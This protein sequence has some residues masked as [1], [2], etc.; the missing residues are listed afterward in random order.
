MGSSRIAA[1][2]KVVDA[3]I[4]HESTHEIEPLVATFGANPEWHN[5][6]GDEVLHGHEAIRT[7][8]AAL[9]AG[10]PDFY[11][12]IRQK[13]VAEEAIVV[14]GYLGGTHRAEWMGIPAT[15]KSMRIPFCVVFT[16]T[17]DDKLKAELTY[18]DRLSILSQLGVM[19]VS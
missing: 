5:M 16:F 4:E 14:E 2:M 3:H 1:R 6:P 15:S 12:D 9:F 10:F 11:L 13:H 17:A 18:F 7:F 19:P 8:Y